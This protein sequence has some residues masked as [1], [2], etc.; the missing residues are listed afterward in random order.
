MILRYF[1]LHF[2]TSLH[3]KTDIFRAKRY[4]APIKIQG[5][6]TTNRAFQNDLFS[7]LEKVPLKW[8]SN[9]QHITLNALHALYRQFP[10]TLTVLSRYLSYFA[11]LQTVFTV[12]KYG[13]QAAVYVV[14][15]MQ[16]TRY[17]PRS[18]HEELSVCLMGHYRANLLQAQDSIADVMFPQILTIPTKNFALRSQ[19]QLPDILYILR[20]T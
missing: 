19:I 18:L 13:K 17:L 20:A 14:N 16:C 3:A 4:A 7:T 5:C 15:S 9:S 6:R 1:N 8:T 11:V 2:S 10:G 12:T